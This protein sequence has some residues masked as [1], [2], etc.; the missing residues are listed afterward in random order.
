MEIIKEKTVCFTGHRPEKLPDGGDASST[1]VKII[2]SMLY[3]EILNAMNDGYDTF[4]TGMQRG[5]DL[6]AGEAVLSFAAEAKLH[7]VAALPY[8][9]IGKSYKN[10]DKWAYGRIIYHAERIVIISDAYTPTCMSERNRY[11]VENS[12]RI[13]GVISNDRSGTGQTMRYAKKLGLD[14]RGIRLEEIFSANDNQPTL[15]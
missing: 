3:D 7:L 6:W 1:A 13:I 4:I 8:R 2:K 11:M 15:L 14:I 9:D 5:V 12:S 10:A